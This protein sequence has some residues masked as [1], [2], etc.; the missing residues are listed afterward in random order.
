[1]KNTRRQTNAD[2]RKKEKNTTRQRNVEKSNLAHARR[3]D[4]YVLLPI[5]L[6]IM[7]TLY[8]QREIFLNF[9]SSNDTSR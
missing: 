3:S 9:L 2:E 6:L 7:C 8:I 5:F 4:F 1:M